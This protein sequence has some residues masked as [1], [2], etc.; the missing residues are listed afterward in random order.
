MS[1]ILIL[2]LLDFLSFQ[3]VYKKKSS[4]N[5]ETPLFTGLFTGI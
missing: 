2:S 5:H 4:F 1:K 3:K